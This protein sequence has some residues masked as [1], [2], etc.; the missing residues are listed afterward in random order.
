ML[1]AGASVS[2]RDS[3]G[4]SALTL[5]L[6]HGNRALVALLLAHDADADTVDGNGSSALKYAF[7]KAP[8]QG[9]RDWWNDL[10]V[11]GADPSVA[12]DDGKAQRLFRHRKDAW[13]R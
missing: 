6:A 4:A 2:K 7:V 1:D 12:D 13:K 3:R 5:A 10:L 8:N 11:A 9:G